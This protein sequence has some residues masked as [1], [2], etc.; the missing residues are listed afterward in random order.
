MFPGGAFKIVGEAIMKCLLVATRLLDNLES[1][2]PFS[3]YKCFKTDPFLF[4]E[5]NASNFVC[6][7]IY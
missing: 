5:I 7:V 1:K 2:Y 6:L 4:F 3:F